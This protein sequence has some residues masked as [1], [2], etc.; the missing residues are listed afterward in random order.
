MDETSWD[1][2]NTYIRG[3]DEGFSNLTPGGYNYINNNLTPCLLDQ[4]CIIAI[5]T[6]SADAKDQGGSWF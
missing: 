1:S 5:V 3:L 4:V 6:E 2:E